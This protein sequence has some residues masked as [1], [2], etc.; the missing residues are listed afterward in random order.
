MP[1]AVSIRSTRALRSATAHDTPPRIHHRARHAAEPLRGARRS[2]HRPRQDRQRVS[3][4]AAIG[5]WSRSAAKVQ[6]ALSRS[7]R[8]LVDFERL[9]IKTRAHKPPDRRGSTADGRPT[10][11][12]KYAN[13]W[14]WSPDV[15]SLLSF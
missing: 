14:R 2:R 5:A 7:L 4:R 15:L 10:M 9:L 8:H 6:G 1:M 13:G 12:N 11:Q 3:R